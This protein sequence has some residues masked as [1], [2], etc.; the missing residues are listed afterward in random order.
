MKKLLVCLPLLL[1]SL[2]LPAQTIKGSDVLIARIPKGSG[3]ADLG[4]A[5]GLAADDAGNAYVHDSLN[6]R[7]LR[8]GPGG[9]REALT[10]GFEF[11]IDMLRMDGDRIVG[12]GNDPISMLQIYDLKKKAMIF[13]I[14]HVWEDASLILTLSR[15]KFEPTLVRGDLLLDDSS[16]RGGYASLQVSPDRSRPSVY[17]DTAE[18]RKLIEGNFGRSAGL[19][20]D[21]RGFLHAGDRLITENP[22]R[23]Q[24]YWYGDSRP[25]QPYFLWGDAWDRRSQYIGTDTSKNS[26]FLRDPDNVDVVDPLG[27]VLRGIVLKPRANGEVRRHNAIDSRGNLYSLVR[28]DAA[29]FGLYRVRRSW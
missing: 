12:F 23:I 9:G 19:R 6:H 20:F 1:L 3:P 14:A 21:E 26:Y 17:R 2:L 5:D 29:Q 4:F 7:I 13:D 22:E 15:K 27:K 18:T 25:A 16:A 8:V 10:P 11:F 24:V 28:M